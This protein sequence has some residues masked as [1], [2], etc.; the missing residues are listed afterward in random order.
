MFRNYL[1]AS[2]GNLRR[3]WLYASV[4]IAGLAVSFA[5]AILIGLYL[6]DEYSFE[7]FIPDQQQVY[8]LGE[9]L[10]LPGSKP[11]VLPSVAAMAAPQLKLDF[12][13]VERTARLAPRGATLK[14]GDHSFQEQMVWADPG[15]FR[16]MP[17]PVLAGDLEAAL[18]APDG[19]V[20]TRSAARKYFGLDAPIGKTVLVNSGIPDSDQPGAVAGDHPMRVLAVLRDLPSNTNL[21]VQV[22]ASA[23]AAFS[24]ISADERRPTQFASDTLAYVKL[25]PGAS[26]DKIR[27]GLKAYADAHFPLYG[28]GPSNYRFRLTPLRDLHFEATSGGQGG[29]LRPPGDRR[30]DAGVG[31]VGALIVII[32]AINFVTLMTARATRRSVEVGVRKAV[33]ARRRDLLLQFM[34]EAL[35]Y[36]LIAMMLA[37]A[38]AEL[39]LPGLNAFLQRALKFDYLSDPRLGTAI[40]AV[41]LLTALLAGLYPSF[42]LSSF[43]PASALKGGATQPSGSAAVRQVLVV[44][45]FAILIGLIVMTGTIYRQTSFALHDALRLDTSQV[46]E[47]GAPCRSAF[48]QEVERLAGVKGVSCGSPMALGMQS[49]KTVIFKREMPV[50]RA[51]MQTINEG[52]VDVG[53]FELHGIKPVAGRFFARSQGQ[54]MVLDHEGPTPATVQPSFVINETAARALGFSRPAYAVG[55]RFAWVR[56]LQPSEPGKI[57]VQQISEIVGVAPDF[58]LG[59]I[60]API[61]PTIYYVH[62]RLGQ[63]LL[64]KVDGASIPETLRAMDQ[65]WKRTGQEGPLQHV[66]ENQTLQDLYKDVVTQEIALAICAGLAILI[67]WA[68]VSIHA[69]LVARAKP[70][71]ALRYE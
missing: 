4:T 36:V 61:D 13:Q 26:A 9:T 53:F 29:G 51:S 52:P 12:P 16:I 48:R 49:S 56:W 33:G 21:D 54:D 55:K 3:N 24:A 15:F 39:A 43:R 38:V 37:V 10:I 28:G 62:P 5:A 47:V 68:T 8:R 22:F 14:A 66:F 42:V 1:A 2:L 25:R 34:G 31:A 35:I 23:R 64:V 59:S 20:L 60:R 70:A 40:L 45:Q 71:M 67:A 19:L 58:S 7:S 63:T 65:T 30:V 57:P 46:L 41:T 17:Y 6:R 18:E 11:F 50:G 69:W 32:A 44:G 27:A